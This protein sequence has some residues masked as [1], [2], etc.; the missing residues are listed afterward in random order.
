MTDFLKAYKVK[1]ND[2]VFYFDKNEI[3]EADLIKKSATEFNCIRKYRSVNAVLIEADTANKKFKI[4]IEGEIFSVEIKDELDQMLEIMGFGMPVNKQLNNIKAPMPGLVLE[5][6]VTEG[7]VVNV[8]DKILILEAMKMENS[9]VVPANATIKKILVSKGQV[10]E[11]GQ[12]LVEL[13]P[14]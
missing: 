11:R 3:A 2:F 1:T 6:T 13:S 7:Q 12:V 10:V 9:L 8:G 5:I 4:A 14:L